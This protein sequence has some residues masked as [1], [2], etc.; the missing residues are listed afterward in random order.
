MQQFH[1]MAPIGELLKEKNIIL[2]GADALSKQGFTQVPNHV[3][4]SDILTP[5]AKLAYAMLLSYAWQNDYCFPG[6]QRLADDMG[7]TDRSVR[8]YLQELEKKG[9]L[10]I[11]RQGQGR[12]NMYELRRPSRLRPSE[13]QSCPVVLE[14]LDPASNYPYHPESR[15]NGVAR[16]QK[17]A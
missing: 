7:V 5:G 6:Q 1:R 3:L 4:R 2:K 8:T 13:Q 17:T 14:A 9:F 16:A 11:K 15:G 10:K 12:T